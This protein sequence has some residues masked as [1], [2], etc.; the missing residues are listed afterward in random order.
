MHNSVGLSNWSESQQD[1]TVQNNSN[2]PIAASRPAA[3]VAVYPKSLQAAIRCVPISP[4][5]LLPQTKNP[6]DNSQ[7]S[8]VCTAV[9]RALIEATRGFSFDT[10]AAGKSFGAP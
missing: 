4:L 5:V 8:R 2:A 10:V 7:K 3:S 9:W 1:Q 6:K